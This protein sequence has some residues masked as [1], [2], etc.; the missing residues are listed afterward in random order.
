MFNA[1]KRTD[2]WTGGRM[3]GKSGFVR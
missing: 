1:D 3:D 2:G